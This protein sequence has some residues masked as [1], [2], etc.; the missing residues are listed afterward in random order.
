M[1]SLRLLISGYFY[2]YGLG[3]LLT[4][5]C[6]YLFILCLFF[7]IL[8][9]LNLKYFRTLNE[10]KGLNSYNFLI[11]AVIVS[12]LSFA[13]M[14][15]LLGFIGKFLLLIFLAFKNQFILFLTF[16]FINLFM[17]FFY[18]QNLKFLICRIIINLL[19]IRAFFTNIDVRLIILVILLNYFNGF[20][21]FFFEDSLFFMN[22]WSSFTY[23]G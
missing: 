8:F 18:T 23:I 19:I 7:A 17:I 12:L 3:I 15:P 22:F 10:I 16:S 21:I 2:E 20:G 6:I 5:I 13:G 11:M 14:P 9:F 1:L 4:N